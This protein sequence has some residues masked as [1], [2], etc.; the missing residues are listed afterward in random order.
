MAALLDDPAQW[1]LFRAQRPDT[2]AD[3]IV[4][5]STPVT[6][7]QRTARAD[8]TLGGQEIRAGQRLG[9]FYRSANFDE[10]VFD[11]PEQFD[12]TRSPNPHLGFGGSGAHYCLGANLARLEASIALSE[13]VARARH[14]EVDEAAGIE[15]VHSINV[16]GFAR[17]PV[18]IG[19]S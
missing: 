13:L 19:R 12:I 14:I 4:R 3:E 7:F 1:E 2:A 18:V 5:W 15:R 8:T 17:L 9:L 11:R 16:R 10:D 6:V